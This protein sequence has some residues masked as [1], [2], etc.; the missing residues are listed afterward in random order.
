M[1][2][3]KAQHR[4]VQ[5]MIRIIR[6]AQDYLRSQGIDQWQDGYPNE[7]TLENDIKNGYSYVAVDEQSVKG[8]FAL[9]FSGEPTYRVIEHGRWLSEDIPYATL[10]RVAVA[11]EEKGKGLAGKMLEE[12]RKICTEQS[13]H[14]IRI[15]THKDN[16]SMRRMLEKNGFVHC[17]VITLESGAPREAYENR[18][19][20][21]TKEM[22]RNDWRR[23]IKKRYQWSE[24]SFH[25]KKGVSSKIQIDEIT[26]PLFVKDRDKKTC[27][28]E[29]GY[30]WIQFAPE[31]SFWYLTSMFDT[32][33]KLL[34]LY[35]DIT[36]GTD[37]SEEGNPKFVDMYLDLVLAAD[38][39][40]CV[41]DEDELEEARQ[42]RI[43]SETEYRR[44][45]EEGRKLF[46]YIT[47]HKEELMEFCRMQYRQFCMEN[48]EE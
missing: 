8:T 42:Q 23:I 31:D 30:S 45:V 7:E 2:I 9:I 12:I 26:E 6:Q 35:F 43:I 33:G 32:E 20:V 40:L 28:V 13:V 48:T 29:R 4:D 41:L 16:A 36:A 38:G 25:G 21:K 24:C 34:Q 44:T 19:S 39:Y 27:I 5:E 17:G 1:I 10:H 18:F 46:S 14:T 37:F 3:R 15:D 22:H 47:A 11:E